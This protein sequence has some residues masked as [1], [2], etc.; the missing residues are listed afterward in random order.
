MKMVSGEFW[1]TVKTNTKFLVISH[2]FPDGDAVGSLLAM[3]RVLKTIGKK[4]T[5][6]IK[7]KIP[8]CFDFLPGINEVK[9]DFDGVFDCV[10]VLDCSDVERV[11]IKANLKTIGNVVVNIDHHPGN[12]YFG[13]INIVDSGVSSVGE[14]LYKL[15]EDFGIQFDTCLG[16]TIFTSIATDTGSFKYSNT[17]PDCMSICSK[18]IGVGV[19]PEKISRFVFETKTLKSL[20]LLQKALSSLKIGKDGLYAWM[21]VPLKIQ[22]ELKADDEDFEGIINYARQIKGVEVGI[23]FREVDNGAKISFRSN[24]WVDVGK[25]ARELGG[26]GHT[27]ASGCMVKGDYDII[28]KRVLDK[29]RTELSQ[30]RAEG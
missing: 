24:D 27:K 2:I 6:V 13:D 23:L 26:G 9:R 17:T 25:L 21:E 11:G 15:F 8:E 20:Q 1:N 10:I 7:D 29:I 30:K 5:M 14:I 19:R 18:L 16:E 3:G 28:K 4:T 12:T 22:A